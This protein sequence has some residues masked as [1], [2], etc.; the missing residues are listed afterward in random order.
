MFPA[1][2]CFAT[3]NGFRNVLLLSHLEKPR[4]ADT[5]LFKNL[6]SRIKLHDGFSHLLLPLDIFPLFE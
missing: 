1:P 3:D 6:I 5:E 4:I 2:E